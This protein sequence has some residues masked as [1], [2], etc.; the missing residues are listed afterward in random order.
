MSLLIV[1][2]NKVYEPWVANC[3]YGQTL[4]VDRVEDMVYT[5][6]A[7]NSST[8]VSWQLNSIGGSWTVLAGTLALSTTRHNQGDV[9]LTVVCY[10]QLVHWL[11]CMPSC[12]TASILMLMA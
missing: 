12:W 9:T 5:G 10:R 3:I 2:R 6:I 11:D 1:P 8:A 4:T 7:G